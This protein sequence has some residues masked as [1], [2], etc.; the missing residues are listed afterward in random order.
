MK[1]VPVVII[2]NDPPPSKLEETLF[3]LM[4]FRPCIATDFSCA[5]FFKIFV[6]VLGGRGDGFGIFFNIR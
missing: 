6:R 3:R 1:H 5:F 4:Q 2:I